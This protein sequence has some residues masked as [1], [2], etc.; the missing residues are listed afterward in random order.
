MSDA[1]LDDF[2]NNER[3]DHL[4]WHLSDGRWHDD[5]RFCIH[6]RKHGGL[7]VPDLADASRGEHR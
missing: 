3:I 1:Q 4:R 5:C 7:G 2:E 6:R